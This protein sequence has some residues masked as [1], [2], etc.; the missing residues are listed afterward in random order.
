MRLQV[1]LSLSRG[2]RQAG[3]V[4]LRTLT[5]PPNTFAPDFISYQDEKGRNS[6]NSLLVISK[7]PK[8]IAITEDGRPMVWLPRRWGTYGGSI[9]P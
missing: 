4:L 5:K 2:Y 9:V 8:M 7:L 6:F 3:T 1:D